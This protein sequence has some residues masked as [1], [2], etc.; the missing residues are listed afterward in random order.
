MSCFVEHIARV[1]DAYEN[2]Q[3]I[4]NEHY[5][6]HLDAD[7]DYGVRVPRKRVAD[8]SN[9]LEAMKDQDFKYIYLLYNYKLI[10]LINVRNQ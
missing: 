10:L 1:A 3:R 4:D 8:R 9:P 5:Q 2:E 7:H 6:E